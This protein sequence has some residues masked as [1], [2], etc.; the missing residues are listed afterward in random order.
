MKAP[1]SFSLG[2]LQKPGR[3]ETIMTRPLWMVLWDFDWFSKGFGELGLFSNPN[4]KSAE[5]AF[6][7]CS[8]TWVYNEA[9]KFQHA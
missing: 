9:R 7:A 6:L 3:Q 1:G 4:P 8:S 2:E 5:Q